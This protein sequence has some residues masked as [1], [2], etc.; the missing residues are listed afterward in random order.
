[1]VLVAMTIDPR[2]PIPDDSSWPDG[3]GRALANL[4]FELVEPDKT[5]GEETSHLLLALRPKP[6][7]QHFDP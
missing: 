1:M 3:V 5:Q 6:T 2:P 4:G 7:L